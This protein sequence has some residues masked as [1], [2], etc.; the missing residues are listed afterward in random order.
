MPILRPTSQSGLVA[1]RPVSGSIRGLRDC[2]GHTQPYARR[3]RRVE[4]AGSGGE[5]EKRL[6]RGSR[7]GHRRQPYSLQT[8]PDRSRIGQ[9]GDDPQAPATGRA[10]AEVGG[11]HPRQQGRPA[12]PMAAGRSA[13]RAV[14]R[15]RLGT[16][17]GRHDAVAGPGPGGQAPRGSAGDET[18]AG[19]PEPPA[20]PAV[21]S[22]RAGDGGSHPTTAF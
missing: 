7:R 13:R 10:L 8:G 6:R 12:Q 21:P 17:L 4:K 2:W 9:G 1:C 11:K 19:G 5:L 18:G 22:E 14:R 20:S 15:R 16:R 3:R